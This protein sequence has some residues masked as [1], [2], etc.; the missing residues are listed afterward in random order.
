MFCF[1]H[2]TYCTGAVALPE[3][4]AVP[5]TT[6]AGSGRNM[7][8]D[9]MGTMASFYSPADVAISSDG[10]FALV[11]DSDRVRRIEIASGQVTTLTGSGSD[12]FSDGTGSMAAFYAPRGVAISS[13]NKFALVADSMNYRVRRIEIATA[14]VTTLA[15]SSEYGNLDGTGSMA[16]FNAP[17]G[18]A[19]SS[20]NTFVLV[21]DQ[22]NNRIRRVDIATAQVT[23]LPALPLVPSTGLMTALDR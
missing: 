6:L 22:Y 1:R 5:L 16:A 9:G 8:A 18:V 20:D 3:A 7:V 13:D 15:G 10:R 17:R 19:I 14:Q 23:T 12:G 4:V 21:A 2:Q 11:A